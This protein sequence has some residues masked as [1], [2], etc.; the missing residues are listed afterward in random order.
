MENITKEQAE[1]EIRE[2]L[3]SLQLNLQSHDYLQKCVSILTDQKN[4]K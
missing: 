4:D 2:A 3:A 1:K